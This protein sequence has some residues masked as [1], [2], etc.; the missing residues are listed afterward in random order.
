MDKSGQHDGQKWS[1]RWTK[2]VN[3]MDKSGHH[4]GQKWSSRWTK[5]VITMDK[6]GHH[7]GQKWS[8]R[9]TNNRYAVPAEITLPKNNFIQAPL[10]ALTTGQDKR[11][12]NVVQREHI[13]EH[14]V[15]LII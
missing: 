7:D 1:T 9:W 13:G 12:L 14:D 6:S 2:V 10:S 15:T 3:T 5:V 8:T 11:E 4:D